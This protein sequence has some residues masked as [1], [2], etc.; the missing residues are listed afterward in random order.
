MA[1]GVR[2]MQVAEQAAYN[3]RLMLSHLRD[4]RRAGRIFDSG[5]A[6]LNGL[7]Q[8]IAVSSDIDTEEKAARYQHIL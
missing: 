3:I 2:D 8:M 7:L 6:E 4:A 1:H 5:V